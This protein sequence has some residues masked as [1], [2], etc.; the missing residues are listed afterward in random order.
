MHKK[1]A[2]IGAGFS[3]LALAVELK[4]HFC[5]T[6]FHKDPIEKSAS[7]LSGGLLHPFTVY[8][9]AQDGTEGVIAT[10]K[11]IGKVTPYA[12]EPIIRSKGILRPI[13]NGRQRDAYRLLARKHHLKLYSKEEVT[14][15]FPLVQADG[16]LWID[17]GLTLNTTSYILAL[18]SYLEAS[19]VQFCEKNI[20]AVS[21]LTCDGA[22]IAAG[23]GSK[24]IKEGQSLPIES[25]KGQILHYNWDDPCPTCN[26]SC[27]I[28][29]D[30]K[31]SCSLG[32]TYEHDPLHL[33]PEENSH[34]QA[35][36]EKALRFLPSLSLHPLTHITT[37]T[38]ACT[39]DKKTPLAMS[40]TEN[41]PFPLWTLT[42]L[43]SKGLLYHALL[44][45]KL[46]AEIINSYLLK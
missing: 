42:G 36:V 1:I 35:L 10:K 16:A 2:I 37:Q 20:F 30:G 44:A 8:G 21:E 29:F 38:R 13:L 39:P 26:S 28:T 41:A 19:G 12:K 5:V 18:K 6:I 40:I 31:G 33:F 45:K 3:G 11:L 46:A 4:E 7:A 14:A 9:Y 43:A 24:T 23:T 32:A 22:I 17:E 15:L 25:V 34:T 27:Y